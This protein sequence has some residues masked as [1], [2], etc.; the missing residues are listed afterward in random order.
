[1][2]AKG[3]RNPWRFSFDRGTGAL[4]IGDVGQSRREE[5]DR[6]R[7]GR[8]PG[9]NLGWNAYE[10][11]LTYDSAAA[12]KLDKDRLVWPVEQYSHD[13]GE[14]V[15]GGYV[16][17]GAAIPACAASTSSAISSAGACGRRTAL[18]HRGSG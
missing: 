16:Y 10:G 12:A 6:L 5:I 18:A 14:S 11:T 4:W 17:R 15:T 7:P 9:A 1:M 13:V 3:L 2:Y 8:P